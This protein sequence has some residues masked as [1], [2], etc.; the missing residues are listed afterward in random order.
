MI[1]R[2]STQFG[3]L[4]PGLIVAI[5]MLASPVGSESAATPEMLTAVNAPELSDTGRHQ[6]LLQYR[7]TWRHS[8]DPTEDRARKAA[9]E[10]CV[11]EFSVFIRGIVRFAMQRKI[12]PPESLYI[13]PVLGPTGTPI[14]VQVGIDRDSAKALSLDGVERDFRDADDAPIRRSASFHDDYLQLTW[15]QD[16]GRGQDRFFLDEMGRALIVEYYIESR[17]LPRSVGYRT[18][19]ER[20]ARSNSESD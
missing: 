10:N 3:C 7:G 19:F 1:P 15:A 20:Q 5:V 16:G 12:R 4:G 11:A 17:Q 8:S 2:N 18:T 9:I 6:R 14:S 13:A